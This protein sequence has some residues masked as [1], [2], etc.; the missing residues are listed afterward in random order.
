MVWCIFQGL[1]QKTETTVGISSKKEFNIGNWV[2]SKPLKKIGVYKFKDGHCQLS[3][4]LSGNQKAAGTSQ[5]SCSTK[6]G[7]SCRGPFKSCIY[8][9]IC[10]CSPT[11]AG[12]TMTWQFFL[13]YLLIMHKIRSFS[14]AFSNQ[15]SAV[16]IL[17]NVVPR[18]SSLE[19]QVRT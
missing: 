12:G 18:P 16:R 7:G 6:L 5:S 8:R 2:L 19:I 1:V 10:I 4:S 11:A 17:G 15:N 14:L 13:S 9:S 3:G